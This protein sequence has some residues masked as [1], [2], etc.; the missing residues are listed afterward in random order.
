MWSHQKTH[1][2]SVRTIIKKAAA[3]TTLYVYSCQMFCVWI[4]V[5]RVSKNPTQ[6][7][8]TV[9]Q[10]QGSRCL[11]VCKQV[12]NKQSDTECYPGLTRHTVILLITRR[13]FMMAKHNIQFRGKLHPVRTD[14]LQMTGQC[15]SYSVIREVNHGAV[16]PKFTL[17]DGLWCKQQ[18]S[19]LSLV[20][21][22]VKCVNSVC[23]YWFHLLSDSRSNQFH[24]PRYDDL[25]ASN[26]GF[27]SA[28]SAWE[29]CSC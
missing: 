26:S 19:W 27:T 3:P 12:R 1:Q 8:K 23:W 29:D 24:L 2:A 20:E 4:F 21:Q 16:V 18:V 22:A 5:C 6:K 10:Q 7:F 9:R 14:G 13:Q 11:T 15:R 25:K 28:T 17:T